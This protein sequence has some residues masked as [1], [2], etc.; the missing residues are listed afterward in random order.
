[1][2][3][4]NNFSPLQS[5]CPNT[6][7]NTWRISHRLHQGFET[8][9]GPSRD[10]WQHLVTFWVVQTG[11][12]GLCTGLWQGEAEKADQHPTGHRRAPKRRTIPKCAEANKLL[13]SSQPR[14]PKKEKPLGSCPLVLTH[15]AAM[16]ACHVHQG[17][18]GKYWDEGWECKVERGG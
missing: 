1:M 10:I 13:W 14:S 2:N 17:R 11:W 15:H 7:P 12:W 16:N 9:G 18:T 8:G 3:S 6:V 5:P 4:G